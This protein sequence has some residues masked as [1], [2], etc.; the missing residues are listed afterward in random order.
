MDFDLRQLEV[1][2]A[3]VEQGSFTRAARRV[4]LSQAAVSERVTNL[5]Q[6]VGGRLLN[7]L[8]RQV[9]ATPMGQLLYR[10][11][12][13]LLQAR[14]GLYFELSELL[15][16][17]RGA[18]TL[19]ASTVSGEYILPGIMA[20][21]SQRFPEVVVHLLGGDSAAVARLVKQG[22]AEAGFVGT[23]TSLPGLESSPLWEDELVLVIPAEH[24]WGRR[25]RVPLADLTDVPIIMRGEG[26]GTRATLE[27][28]LRQHGAGELRVV[29]ELGSTGAVKEGVL[30]GLG[31]SV[32]SRRALRTELEAGLVRAIP[33]K[34]GK[35][36]RRFHLLW[37]PRRERSPICARF[38]EALARS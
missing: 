9:T 20:A 7:R 37:D 5:E 3:V 24:P 11:A 16:A 23:P 26:S 22:R 30:R 27:A 8:G 12:M 38:I 17:R 32:I 6:S 14:E 4:H 21:F 1:F 18:L 28:F 36:L 35:I 15:G 13:A 10:R 34:E 19:A 2:C 33:F 25:R 31:L 29:A